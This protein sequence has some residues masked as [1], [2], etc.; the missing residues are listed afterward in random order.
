MITKLAW[1]I[2][3]AVHFIPAL[4]LFFPNLLEKLY[5]VPAKEDLGLLLTHR[6]GLFLAV[7]VAACVA[8]NMPEARKVSSLVVAISVTSFLILY[9]QAGMPEGALRKIAITDAVAV[10]P[11][12]WVLWEA[13]LRKSVV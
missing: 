12:L 2:L 8:M 1:A 10:I 5:N 9:W 6:G 3:A 11:L 4:T 13:W 7:M